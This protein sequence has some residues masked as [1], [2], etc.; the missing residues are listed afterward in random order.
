MTF[1]IIYTVIMSTL[2]YKNDV[3]ELLYTQSAYLIDFILLFGL[4]CVMQ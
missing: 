4:V 2:T 3:T 1:R